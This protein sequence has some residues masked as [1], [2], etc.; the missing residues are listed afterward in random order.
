MGLRL[1]IY[2]QRMLSLCGSCV[3]LNNC[4]TQHGNLLHA[5]AKY[6]LAE[7]A[8]EALAQG[9]YNMLL[10]LDND[11]PNTWPMYYAVENEQWSTIKIFLETLN[12]RYPTQQS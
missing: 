11:Q 1:D 2:C 10:E 6:G 3:N 7:S 9:Y 5:A 8:K 4:H 12:F